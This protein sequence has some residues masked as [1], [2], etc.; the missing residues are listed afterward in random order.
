MHK[1]GRC[2]RHTQQCC[3]RPSDRCS[4]VVKAPSGRPL[5]TLADTRLHTYCIECRRE[6]QRR[7]AGEQL[8]AA[9]RLRYLPRCRLSCEHRTRAS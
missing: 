9:N 2:Y 7:A 8:M 4:S 3:S 6:G 5:S 1:N